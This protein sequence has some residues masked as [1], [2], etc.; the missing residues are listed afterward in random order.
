MWDDTIYNIYTFYVLFL[1]TPRYTNSH[2]IESGCAFI[3]KYLHECVF[4]TQ[5]LDRTMCVCNVIIII[6][7][8]DNRPFIVYF[9][10]T[11]MRC[12]CWF[13]RKFLNN[14]HNNTFLLYYVI[15]S[16]MF[17]LTWQP[18]NVYEYMHFKVY[19]FFPHS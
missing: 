14:I 4:Y 3:S 16:V 13:V 12:A 19:Y 1:K 10:Y 9:L 6:K 15:S 17:S 11:D 2:R 5:K 8:I 7:I 18:T